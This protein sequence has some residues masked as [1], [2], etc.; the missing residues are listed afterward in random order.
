MH[1]G[2]AMKTKDGASWA[3]V[4]VRDAS[5]HGCVCDHEDDSVARVLADVRD[6]NAMKDGYASGWDESMAVDLSAAEEVGLKVL[7]NRK[8][9]SMKVRDRVSNGYGDAS[10]LDAPDENENEWAH[11]SGHGAHESGDAKKDVG[12]AKV[13]SLVHARGLCLCTDLQSH[14]HSCYYAYSSKEKP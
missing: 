2:R 7:Q 12:F 1:Y 4:R 13:L 11:A 5:G 8:A 3:T 10:V 6:R 9:R 14:R